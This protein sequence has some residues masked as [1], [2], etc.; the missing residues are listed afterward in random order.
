MRISNYATFC[1]R[2]LRWIEMAID[3]GLAGQHPDPMGGIQNA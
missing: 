1:L 2:T 3:L